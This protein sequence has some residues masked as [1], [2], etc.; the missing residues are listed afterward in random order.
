MDLLVTFCIQHYFV[1]CW[2][3][4]HLCFEHICLSV[5]CS[6]VPE[7][8]SFVAFVFSRLLA[9]AVCLSLLIVLVLIL[10]ACI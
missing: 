8:G 4:G 3:V 10:G 2:F 7:R 5:N 1:L 9:G 6:R